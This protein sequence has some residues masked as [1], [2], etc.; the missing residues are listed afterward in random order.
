V[1]YIPSWLKSSC[2]ATSTHI[3]SKAEGPDVY[4]HQQK[5]YLPKQGLYVPVS[6]FPSDSLSQHLLRGSQSGWVFLNSV[7]RP[8]CLIWKYPHI[9]FRS[10][11]D[12]QPK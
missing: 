3:F 9:E 1:W 12:W 10:T 11:L 4:D 6:V 5:P 2:R 7:H 8:V